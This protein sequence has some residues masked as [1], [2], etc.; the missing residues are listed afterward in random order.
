MLCIEG[1]GKV[2][3]NGVHALKGVSFALEPYTFTAILGSSGAGKST[4]LRTIPRLVEP[5]MGSIRF[6]GQELT[7][8]SDRQL[9][10]ARSRISLIGQQV[11]LVRRNSVVVNCL[12]GR[13]RELPV[14]RIALGLYPRAMLIEA[15][16]ALDRV[17]L[18]GEAF[19]RSDQ[20]SGGQQQRV[21]VARALTQ[22]AALLLGDEP[23]ASLDPQ[24]SAIVLDLLREL[25]R[26][27]RLTVLCNLHQ[28]DLACRFADR[29]LGLRD[30]RLVYDGSAGTF[31]AD[32][33]SHIYGHDTQRSSPA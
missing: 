13:L 28:V 19:R 7:R 25:C 9:G 17:R 5:T 18:I 24:N 27:R 26:E 10:H 15:M 11:T 16:S 30:G 14:W 29:L 22:H 12:A 3:A 1:L 33:E 23:V 2:Y 21:A 20:I 32:D 6:D 8:C 4:L 31:T